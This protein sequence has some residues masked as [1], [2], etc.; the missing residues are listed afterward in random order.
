MPARSNKTNAQKQKSKK[1]KL[2]EKR[3]KD[4]VKA[5]TACENFDKQWAKW[6]GTESNNNNSSNNSSSSSSST[7]K[8]LRTVFQKQTK[9]EVEA[10]KLK[11][12]QPLVRKESSV[13]EK[14]YYNENLIDMPKRPKW[15][16]SQS[17]EQLEARE[18][19]Y[20]Q[21][22]LEDI[23]S[24]FSA[25]ALNH[26]EHNLQVWRQLWRVCEKS[27][28]LVV[29]VD[30]R[31]PLFHLPA[32]LYHYVSSELKKP[33]V[34]LLN[35]IDLISQ[36]Q[37]ARWIE[38]FTR[39]YPELHIVPFS[40]IPVSG[41]VTDES[42]AEKKKERKNAGGLAPKVP[43][44]AREL[45]TT[46]QGVLR[47]HEGI[48]STAK[49]N[50]SFRSVHA[51]NHADPSKLFRGFGQP[52]QPGQEEKEEEGGG[53]GEEEE[54]AEEEEIIREQSKGLT[55]TLEEE[56]ED[57]DEGDEGD[58]GARK[59]PV[60]FITIGFVGHPNAGKSSVINALAGR[61]LVSVSKTPG[62]T[63]HLQ[64]L[65]L[66]SSTRLCDCP[67]LVFP[68]VGMP[69]EMQVLSGLFPIAQTRDPYSAVQFLAERVPLERIYRLIPPGETKFMEDYPWSA[70]DICESYA[71][72]L[73]YM[74][75]KGTFDTYRAANAL[76]RDALAGVVVLAFD[77]PPVS[78]DSAH[79]ASREERSKPAGTENEANTDEGS[80]ND[81]SAAAV[82][83][84]K[85]NT[86]E[87]SLSQHGRRFELEVSNERM[88]S[89]RKDL[90]KPK[91]R[92]F[93][94]S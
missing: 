41:S 51:L 31:H 92:R 10:N 57:E 46:I 5:A 38:Y 86:T 63:K 67:G 64:T 89:D 30:A 53:K 55:S 94:L 17:K 8:D 90:S 75:R 6:N 4:K 79:S 80:D 56:E 44:G 3:A 76:L 88:Q 28:V 23:H 36:T 34:L 35:K 48:S 87:N 77:P 20:F 81:C 19:K 93:G 43:Y 14:D 7:E 61:K 62:H 13:F 15:E 65:F 73:H 18:Q 72:K 58:E 69:K 37:V 84:E 52:V 60:N 16:T 11:S 32:S 25:D 85:P 78:T 45:E 68:A 27:D 70:W 50:V 1:E 47:A 21:S 39:K 33:I 54:E 26:F 59:Q 9:E 82:A 74:T 22:W 83:T 91:G 71:Q 24:R 29:L 66:N 40:C 49:E 42:H 12:Q 2:Q